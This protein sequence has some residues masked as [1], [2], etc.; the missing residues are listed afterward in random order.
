[1]QDITWIISKTFISF[2]ISIVMKDG[3]TCV[4]CQQNHQLLLL[5]NTGTH[6]SYIQHT[7]MYRGNV[8]TCK[9]KSSC[10]LYFPWRYFILSIFDLLLLRS[11]SFSS[12]SL[13][14][15]LLLFDEQVWRR[16]RWVNTHTHT[17]RGAFVIEFCIR[18]INSSWYIWKT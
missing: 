6:G 5:S 3:A 17:S 14:S 18:C 15:S 10:T 16:K 12:S 2:F 11:L 8:A 13:S 9:H 4:T 7:Y 1:M